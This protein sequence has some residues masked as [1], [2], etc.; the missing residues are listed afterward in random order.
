MLSGVVLAA[1][2]ARQLLPLRL[3][4]SYRFLFIPETIGAITWLALNEAKTRAIR[5]GLVATC[6]EDP[7]QSTY[8]RSRGGTAEIDRAAEHVL[9][10]SGDP[11]EILDFFPYGSD[12]RQF[13][14]PG[15]DLPVGSLM[16]TPYGRFPEYHTSADDLSF[17]QPTFLADTFSKYA[18]ILSVI[19]RNRTYRNLNPKCEPQLGRRGLYSRIGGQKRTPVDE[20][21]LLWVLNYSDGQHSLLDVADRSGIEFHMVEAAACALKDANLL[22]EA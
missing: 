21:A 22:A 20:T 12:E 2:L 8:K 4:Y 13:C 19:E 16:R 9:R 10:H 1:A 7:G 17:V 18:R 6:C 14:S 5:H 15:L 11:Y 3:R